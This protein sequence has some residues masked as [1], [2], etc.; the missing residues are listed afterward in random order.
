MKPTR[1]KTV[2]GL[3]AL[4]TG[5]GA[6]FS[7]GAFSNAVANST[8]DI[9]VVVEGDLIVEAGKAFRDGD[10]ANDYDPATADGED[11]GF[12]GENTESLF[13]NLD[14][15]SGNTGSEEEFDNSNTLT[16]DDLPA[17]RVNSERAGNGLNIQVALDSTN[18]DGNPV[19]VTFSNMLQVTNSGTEIAEVGIGY[20]QYGEDAGNGVPKE[21]IRHAF[22][23]VYDGDS[24]TKRISPK[25]DGADNQGSVEVP[26]GETKQ[27]DLD[28]D[29]SR[30]AIHADIADVADVGQ[31][32]FSEG[33]YD[34]VD[35]LDQVKFG[36]E[37]AEGN[38]Q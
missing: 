4:A 36:D 30:S 28:I 14:T 15:N 33:T 35:L 12:Y 16:V 26:I 25:N 9:G 20:S 38:Q 13:D 2:L 31:K 37:L 6:V 19:S 27:I 21:S 23:F 7:S 24:N 11:N 8:A 3:G 1:R 29:L 18:N 34:T 32:A 17:A 5:S 10:P 22:Q